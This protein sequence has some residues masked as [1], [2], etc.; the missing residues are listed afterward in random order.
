MTYVPPNPKVGAH[1][2]T[3]TYDGSD[4]IRQLTLD[5]VRPIDDPLANDPNEAHVVAD[6]I[7]SHL[8]LV[9]NGVAQNM[10]ADHV[11]RRHAR[12][13]RTGGRAHDSVVHDQRLPCAARARP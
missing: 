4:I 8:T 11:A 3:L 10:G 7:P 13:R 2:A 6:H 9:V 12:R 1:E 5:V